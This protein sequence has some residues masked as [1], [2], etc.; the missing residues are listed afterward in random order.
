[1]WEL[2]V[3]REVVN[4]QAVDALV[5][6]DKGVRMV[7]LT[8]L[9]AEAPFAYMLEAAHLLEVCGV[10]MTLPCEQRGLGSDAV[11]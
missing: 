3:V 11:N 1:V 5:K 7:T 9:S 6:H 2:L 4:G 8:S 10:K